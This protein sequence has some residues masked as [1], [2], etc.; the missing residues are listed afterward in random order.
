MSV[1]LAELRSFRQRLRLIQQRP[2]SF[3]QC[4]TGQF[5]NQ[6]KNQVK[7]KMEHQVNNNSNFITILHGK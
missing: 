1:V 3:C 6:V 5:A 4:P 2:K 7:N